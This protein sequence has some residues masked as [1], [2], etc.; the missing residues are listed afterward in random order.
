MR[1]VSFFIHSFTDLS[2]KNFNEI[3]V[4]NNDG[5][6]FPFDVS[7][8]NFIPLIKKSP[9]FNFPFFQTRCKMQLATS[10]ISI[11]VILSPPPSKERS[12]FQKKLD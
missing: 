10:Y 6:L 9:V 7:P 1:G 11:L 4:H 8:V 5:R 12:T 2:F 3:L